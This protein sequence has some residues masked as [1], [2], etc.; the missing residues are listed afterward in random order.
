MSD[1]WINQAVMQSLIAEA[2][3]AYPLETG[4]I[5]VGYVAENGEPVVRDVIGPGPHAIH[6]RRRFTPDHQWQCKQLD[7]LYD[8]S[9]GLLVYL[10]DWHTHPDGVPWMSWLDQRTLKKIATHSKARLAQPLMVIGGGTR[11]N[12]KWCCHQHHE[13]AFFNLFSKCVIG[14]LRISI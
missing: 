13:E 11:Q 6:R 12:W 10:G 2:D 14:T 5:L 1:C 4:G 3:R 9:S 8:Q 7:E